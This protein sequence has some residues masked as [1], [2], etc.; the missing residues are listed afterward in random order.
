MPVEARHGVLGG[1]RGLILVI[2][3]E[4]FYADMQ[5]VHLIQGNNYTGTLRVEL[6]P[7]F[8]PYKINFSIL[9]PLL[10]PNC[11]TI[12]ESL[13]RP[14]E[15]L[16]NDATVSLNSVHRSPENATHEIVINILDGFP[17]EISWSLAALVVNT[18]TE[19]SPKKWVT[20]DS[21][22]PIEV[23]RLFLSQQNNLTEQTLYKVQINDSYGDGIDPG[24][25]AVTNSSSRLWKLPGNSFT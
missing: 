23:R 19:Q 4:L 17:P 7:K 5:S 1:K 11:S 9:G 18:P 10:E 14:C 15:P 13:P 20:I 21:G 3:A 12:C 22:S 2:L 24:F 16:S 8:C 6:C 25:V